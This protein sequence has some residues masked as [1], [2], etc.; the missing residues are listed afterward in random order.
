MLNRPIKIYQDIVNQLFELPLGLLPENRESIER[1]ILNRERKDFCVIYNLLLQEKNKKTFYQTNDFQG[2]KSKIFQSGRHAIS[3]TDLE[4]SKRNQLNGTTHSASVYSIKT[5]SRSDY[6][7]TSKK[8]WTYGKPIQYERPYDLMRVVCEVLK[9]LNF[10]WKIESK[11]YKLKCTNAMHVDKEK[12]ES[13][14]KIEDFLNRDYLK[15]I[16]NIV[17]TKKS[18]NYYTVDIQLILGC[19]ISFLDFC[20]DFFLKLEQKIDSSS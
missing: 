4:I 5:Y 11:E 13:I 17:K 19:P 18:E 14:A 6:S 15:F 16:V 8:D 12:L 20:Q 1:S 2:L 10:S 7:H 9:L 3:D